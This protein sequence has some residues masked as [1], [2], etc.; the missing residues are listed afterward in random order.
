MCCQNDET[1]EV[2]LKFMCLRS[3]KYLIIALAILV[4]LFAAFSCERNDGIE[5]LRQNAEESDQVTIV[6]M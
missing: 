3:N 6:Y 5:E 4:H 2:L 1:S